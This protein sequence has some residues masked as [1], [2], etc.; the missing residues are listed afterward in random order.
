MELTFL[1]AAGEVGRSCVLLSDS[2]N[3]MLD[4]G[5][6]IHASDTYPLQPPVMPDFVVLS[7]AH[8]DHSGFLPALYRQGRPELVCTPP[9]LAMGELIIQDSIKI[10]AQRGEFP[11]KQAHVKRMLQNST[12][13]S[14]HKWYELGEASLTFYNAGHIPG[15]AM[16]EI[17][18]GRR[19]VVYSGDFKLE[20]TRTTFASV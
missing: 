18:F 7:H 10:M 12:K 20:E 8:L 3:I 15:A 17:D 13:L 1:G 14:Y 4:C 6:K 5:L 11:F 2:E 9:T 16:P 19:R